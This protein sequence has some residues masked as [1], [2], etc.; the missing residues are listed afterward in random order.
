[1]RRHQ[2]QFQRVPTQPQTTL[3]Q[4]QMTRARCPTPG[5]ASDPDSAEADPSSPLDDLPKEALPIIA[6]VILAILGLIVK[7][8]RR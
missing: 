2:G 7:V 6:A 5:A 1:M 3:I 8:I 4:H